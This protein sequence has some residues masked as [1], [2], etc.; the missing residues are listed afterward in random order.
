LK[1]G[2]ELPR[3]AAALPGLVACHRHDA[4][5][6]VAA[7]SDRLSAQVWIVALLAS[8]ARLFMAGQSHSALGTAK[9]VTGDGHDHRA[10]WR[11]DQ[12]APAGRYTMDGAARI[13]EMK[14]RG[15][16]EAREQ[17]PELRRH[18]FDREAEPFVPFHSL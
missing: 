14:N 5:F 6:P 1:P 9:I 13:A 11:V 12:T 16:T 4:T 15:F 3:K 8:L 17:L 2:D 10:I 18:F 7:N